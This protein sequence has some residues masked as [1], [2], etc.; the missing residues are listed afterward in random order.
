LS[1]FSETRYPSPSAASRKSTKSPYPRG[2]LQVLRIDRVDV[3]ARRPVV[4]QHMHELPR[5]QIPGD[6]PLRAHQDAVAV[7][8][9]LHRYFA[10]VGRQIAPHADRLGL[11][12]H[13][14]HSNRRF[15]AILRAITRAS[16]GSPKRMHTSNASSLSGGGFTD[17]CNCTS[18]SG[19]VR[20]KREITG[21]M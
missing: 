20:T 14:A 10:I 16:G 17:S 13:A 9:P 5:A 11:F 1:R 12:P 4:R 7:E 8:R 15:G 18:T 3:S 2:H 6:I 21:A 19:N